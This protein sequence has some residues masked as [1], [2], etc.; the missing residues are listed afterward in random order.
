[1][2]R[3]ATVDDAQAILAIYSHYVLNSHSTFEM[4]PPSL[5]SMEQK[6][7]SASHP[8][9]IYQEDG[10]L[11]YA[12]AIHW[13]T[14]E[15]YQ[16]TCET[17]IYLSHEVGGQGIGS[18][19]YQA[20]IDALKHEGYHAIIGGISLPNEASIRLHEKLG[21]EKIAQFKEVGYKFE[22]WIDVGYWELVLS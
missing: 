2:I 14:R 17:S 21:F 9:L 1:M 4:T 11:G 18:Q 8:W 5:H 15:A 19:L 12:Y 20:L 22:K 10:V 13:K 7:S 6:I 16:R 3:P